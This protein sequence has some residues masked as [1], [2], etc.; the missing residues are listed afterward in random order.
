MLVLD[1]GLRPGLP[2]LVIPSLVHKLTHSGMRQQKEL[3]KTKKPEQC[4]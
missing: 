1:L 2:L 3:I 4:S